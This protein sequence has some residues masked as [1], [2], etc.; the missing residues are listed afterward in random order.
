MEQKLEM[1]YSF[2]DFGGPIHERF[3]LLSERELYVVD[4]DDLFA[5]YLAAFPEG[6]NPIFR[7]RNEHDCS[8]CKQFIR[9]LGKVI[10]IIDDRIETVWDVPDLPYPYNVVAEALDRTVRQAPI[11][12]VYR[13]KERQ[14]GTDHNFDTQTNQRWDH[15]HAR[16]SDNHFHRDPATIRGRLNE[17][18]QMLTRACTELQPSAVETVIDLIESN[19]LY[20]GEEHLAA[21]KQF[22][23]LQ[24]SFLASPDRNLFAWANL[25]SPGVRFRNT[26]IGTLVTDISSGTDLEAAVR[27][28]ESKVAP[29]N[30]KRPTALITPKMIDQALAKITELGLDDALNRRFAKL[31]DVSVN[32]VLFV[33]RS[34]RPHMKGGL[35]EALMQEA[36]KPTVKITNPTKMSG[37]AF[38]DLLSS[39][40]SIQLL[41]ENR[42]LS[43]FVSLTTGDGPGLFKWN[44]PFGWSYDGD[45]TDSIKERVKKAGGNITAPIRFSLSWFNYDDLDI[46]VIEPSGQHI[47]YGSKRGHYG[48]LDVDMNAGAGTTPRA[49]R[50]R[51]VSA[52]CRRELPGLRQQLLPPRERQHRLRDRVRVPWGH[53]ALQLPA[54]GAQPWRHRSPDP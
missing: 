22:Q 20:R 47:Y 1:R 38:L 5:T 32:D 16:I 39:T 43:N 35:H 9:N 31:S 29:Q 18:A 6:T 3:T 19:N 53:P 37:Q 48:V 26:V 4:I 17:N 36:K 14:Y 51:G 54:G 21:I 45:V 24:R 40:T 27:M 34:A 23:N 50:E 30:Y 28:F 15:F 10:A 2:K 33:D 11:I 52:S 46:H 44:N 8:C 12:S 7:E 41:L 49:G 42:H 25:N 13:T